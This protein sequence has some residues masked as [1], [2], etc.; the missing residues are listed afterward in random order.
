M[1]M[2]ACVW[3]KETEM[4]VTFE[5]KCYDQMRRRWMRVWD[6]RK[7]GNNTGCNKRMCGGEERERRCN[8]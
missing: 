6:G 2:C 4:H 1:I 8:I 3:S 5:C 7:K